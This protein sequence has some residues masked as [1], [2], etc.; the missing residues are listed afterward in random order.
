MASSFKK[1]ELKL[2]L[3]T[4]LD[5]LLMFEEGIR[6]RKCHAIFST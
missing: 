2:K 6:G 3:L 4:D 5:M 1:T